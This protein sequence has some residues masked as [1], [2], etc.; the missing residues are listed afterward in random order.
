MR[1]RDIINAKHEWAKQEVEKG[2]KVI[3]DLDNQIKQIEEQKDKVRKQLLKLDGIILV[4]DDIN[5]EAEKIAKQEEAAKA[6][7]AKKRAEEE[8]KKAAEEEESKKKTTRKRTRK[9][10]SSKK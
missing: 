1:L 2:H 3:A 4:L 8:S 7:E 10:K 9:T 5:S 6:A